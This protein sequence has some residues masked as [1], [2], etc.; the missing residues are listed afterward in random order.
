M[1]K[2]IVF[3]DESCPMKHACKAL[4]GKWKIPVIYVLCVNGTLRYSELKQALGITNVMLSST[5]KDLEQEGLILR[6]SYNEIPPRV[7]YS[8]SKS[9]E[10]LVPIIKA[11]ARWGASLM[12][13]QQQAANQNSD[14]TEGLV[15]S[16]EQLGDSLEEAGQL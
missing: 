5:L 13:E 2:L 12:C 15:E 14:E 7:D 11:F 8:L 4:E 3:Q 16:E 1:K 6:I 10:G 9:G